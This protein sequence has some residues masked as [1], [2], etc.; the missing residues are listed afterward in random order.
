MPIT[1]EEFLK[2]IESSSKNTADILK[3][4]WLPDCCAIIDA[5]QDSIE[6]LMPQDNEVIIRPKSYITI[7]RSKK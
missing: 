2:E 3:T 4:Q 7:R 5:Q 1:L 6:S